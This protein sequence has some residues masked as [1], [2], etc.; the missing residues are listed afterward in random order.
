[1]ICGLASRSELYPR[2]GASRRIRAKEVFLGQ[3]NTGRIGW[4]LP[5]AGLVSAAIGLFPA[6]AAQ[7]Q[8]VE[9][10]YSGKQ[11]K[12]LIGSSAGTGYDVYARLVGR[13]MSRHLPG[14]PIFIT[15]NMPGAGGMILANYLYNIAPSDGSE[16]AMLPRG[17]AT[18]P[19]LDPKDTGPKYVATKFN[20]IGT[21]QQEVG[22]LIVR[23]PSPIQTIA[24]VKTHELILAGT[25]AISPSS[26]YPKVIN[27]L[28]DTKFKVVEGYKSSQEAFLALDRGEVDGLL[29]GSSSGALRERIAPWVKEGKV[30]ILAQ[31]GLEKDRDY[32]DV[33]LIMD[34]G[35]TNDERRVME[36]VFTQ[37]LMAWPISAPPGVPPERVKALRDAFDATMKDPEF[38]A[39]AARQKLVINAVSGKKIAELLD[40]VYATPQELLDR[41]TALSNN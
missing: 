40:R 27:K 24:D 22:L 15:P 32:P 29:S 39:E 5:I 41:V 4:M 20:W 10:F 3:T 6:S 28:L 16:I 33:P 2:G 1:M 36:L 11:V 14:N 13:F 25:S 37:Q 30:K 8:S 21:P 7:A 23:Q 35:A 26:Y 31:I 17:A 18:Q 9:Q 34:L 19:L 38:L 12:F